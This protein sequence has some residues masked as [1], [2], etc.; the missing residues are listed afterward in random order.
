MFPDPTPSPHLIEKKLLRTLN[1]IK[2]LTKKMDCLIYA[3]YYKKAIIKDIIKMRSL[4]S[5]N[6]LF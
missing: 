4:S 2:K 1:Q 5:L 3:R 6:A